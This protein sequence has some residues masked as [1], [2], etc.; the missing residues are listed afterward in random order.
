MSLVDVALELQRRIARMQHYPS[1]VKQGPYGPTPGA[2]MQVCEHYCS[3]WPCEA[4][5]VAEA[6]ESLP[7]IIAALEAAEA[8]VQPVEGSAHATSG[9]GWATR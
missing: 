3:I 8:T 4:A 7:Q 6:A 9:E 2:P 5:D 1:T